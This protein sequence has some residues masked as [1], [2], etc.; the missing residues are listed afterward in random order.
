MNCKMANRVT[1]EM[2][3]KYKMSLLLYHTF[4]DEIPETD[5]LS[6]NL[7]QIIISEIISIVF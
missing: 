6:L 2:F 3:L 5:W 4:N 1:T 7:K